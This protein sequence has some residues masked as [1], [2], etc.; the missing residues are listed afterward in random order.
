MKHAMKE[1][2]FWYCDRNY[3]GITHSIH[4]FQH[5]KTKVHEKLGNQ[6]SKLKT[7]AKFVAYVVVQPMPENVQHVEKV[8]AIFNY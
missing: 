1:T 3:H 4:H 7:F 6:T 2:P 5:R 8:I